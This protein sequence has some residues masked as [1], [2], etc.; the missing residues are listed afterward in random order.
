MMADGNGLIA[1]LEFYAAMVRANRFTGS[2]LAVAFMLLYR[3]LN[4]A[5]G[6]CDPTV[7]V[8]VEE[9]GLSRR[10]VQ[11]AI[12]DLEQ[13]GWWRIIGSSGA[14]RGHSNSYRPTF[15]KANYASPFNPK[16]G[17]V[18]G[19]KRRSAPPIIPLKYN[20]NFL[21]TSKNQERES[22]PIVPQGGRES[23]LTFAFEA[24]WAVYPTRSPH[25]NPKKPALEKFA[26]AARRGADQ[27][28][29]IRGAQN[30]ALYAKQ[31]IS[32]RRFIKQ[33]GT[34][35]SQEC[36]KEYQQ[37]PAE[38]VPPRKKHSHALF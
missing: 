29:I 22:P 28:D 25:P 17:E 21:T 34:W 36:W 38:A 7:E 8:L 30:Y 13:S 11:L 31:H 15:A 6:R 20:D 10:G 9:T 23:D 19:T 1:R 27:A 5:T 16:K 2:A 3:H 12:R 26:A 24:F 37:P 33:A 35:L 32:D 18:D 14:G 4:G